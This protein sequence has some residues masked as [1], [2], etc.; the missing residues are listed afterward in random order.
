MLNFIIGFGVG[1]VVGIVA[2]WIYKNKAIKA[3]NDAL[4][5]IADKVKIG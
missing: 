5:K 4:A 2:C 1:C 3:A